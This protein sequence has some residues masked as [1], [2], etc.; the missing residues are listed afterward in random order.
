M[1]KLL[2]FSFFLA[3]VQG[4]MAQQ[5]L[6]IYHMTDVPQSEYV[7]VSRRPM[8][9]VNIGL[10]LLSSIY[11]RHNNTIFNPGQMFEGSGN[12]VRFRTENWQEKI[13]KR[14]YLANDIA[15]D[16]LS[17]GFAVGEKNY[18]SLSIREKIYTKI[19]LPGDLLRFPFTGNANFS[20]LDDGTL[21]FSDLRIALNH[22]REYGL[23]WHHELNDT[24]QIGGRLKYLYGMENVDTKRSSYSWRTDPN[25]WDWTMNGDVA[26]HTSGL[27]SLLDTIDG[28]SD[29]EDGDM[30]GYLFGRK[31]HGVGIDLGASYTLAEKIV[32]SVNLI[33]L[34]FISWKNDVSNYV[35][36]D[37]EFVYTG[38]P[39]SSEFVGLDD[40]GADSVEVV[41]DALLEDFQNT[42]VGSQDRNSYKSSLNTRFYIGAEYNVY[43]REKHSGKAG[44]LFQSE[45]YKG[46]L[47]PTVTLSYTERLGRWLSASVAYSLMDRDF[48]NLGVGLR[49]NGGPIQLYVMADNLLALRMTELKFDSSSDETILYPS[50]AR[51]TMVHAGI[52]LTFGRK[53]KD[54]D[55]D[56]IVDKKDDCPDVPGLP[57]LN[58]CPDADLDGIADAQDQCPH[59]PGL[60]EF[61]G[62]PDTD[63]DGIPDP[64]D[65]CPE[66]PGLPA[67]AGCP[68]TDSD[69]IKD[70]DD[71]CPEVAGLEQF[72]GCPDTDGDGIQD[73]EDRCV[74]VPGILEFAGCPDT[75]KDGIAD[76]DDACPLQVGPR[77]N[78]GCPW[79]DADGDGLTDNLDAC[80]QV[81]GPPE[82]NGCPYSDSDGDGL[83]DLEDDCP[84]TPGPIANRGCPIIEE[85]E[86][87]VLNTAFENL[88]FLSGKDVIKD[89]SFASLKELC[90]LLVKKS[91]WK[92][93]IAG[94]TD[95]VG[96]AKKNMILSKK[97]A[98]A[99]GA[100][101]E[102]QGV[103]TSRLVVKWFGE[104][105]PIADNE[106]NEGRQRNRRV[107]MKVVFD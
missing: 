81:A 106:T 91:E 42:F 24:W 66:T 93:E 32:I 6:L 5:D 12:N 46:R 28:N 60:A 16:L 104:D 8:S 102:S 84:M 103:D 95:A 67:F 82:N 39:Y 94:H 65:D 86:Q 27:N 14:N 25:T 90:E 44:L 33:D 89:E 100:Y 30:K 18:F 99:V 51:N 3:F 56:G 74:E 15:I 49:L 105:Q 9:R 48:R 19:V 77:E 21:D 47:R 1:K 26:I 83:V 41:V 37:G 97:R 45:I 71:V 20:E 80:P 62:C 98:Q 10:P 63:S 17:I 88:E 55:G 23:S 58:G 4:M 72:Q 69:G 107:E 70:G 59:T 34:G 35:A 43:N 52:N 31:N 79:G 2:I 68:D 22:Y 13:R 76:P 38:I 101:I 53:K 73:S 96:D 57:A 92:L 50:Y 36:Q 61:A 54:R 75:D 78:A 87:E 40:N 7:N 64:S 85:E 11:I 29:I